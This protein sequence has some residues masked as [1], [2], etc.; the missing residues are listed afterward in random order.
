MAVRDVWI[1]KIGQHRGRP[2]LFLDGL[3]AVRAGFSPGQRF[4]VEVDGRRVVI[5]RNQDGSRVVSSRKKGPSQTP[6]V[7]INSAELLAAFEGM[8]AIRVVVAPDR[9]YLLP[10]ASQ[11]RKV[12]RVQRLAG[13]LATGQAL[14]AGSV[15]HGGGVLAHA[16]HTGLRDAGIDCTLEFANELR[17]DL[18]EQAIVHNDI[19]SEDTAALALPMQELAQDEWLL[20][21]LP[22]LELLEMGLPCSGASIAGHTKKGLQKME[23]HEQVGHL[24]YSALV[25]ISKTNPAVVLLENVPRYADTAS[26]AILRAQF[27]DMG[28]KTAEFLLDGQ[29]FGALEK[30]IRW[31]MVATTHGVEIDLQDLAPPVRLVRRLAEVLEPDIG[32][33]DPRWSEV[34]YLKDKEARNAAVGDRFKMQFVDASSTSVPTLRRHYN[35]GGSSDPRLRHPDPQR[36]ELSRLLTPVEHAGVKGVPPSLIAGLARTTAHELLGQGIAYEPF[37]AVGARIGQ[38][39]AQAAERLRQ[40]HTQLGDVEDESGEQVLYRRQSITG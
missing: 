1:K 7:D 3:Q 5:S 6:V 30:R 19:W 31:C 29:D 25:I 21:N 33:D 10:L 39:L 35:K 16:V 40:G 20:A 14:A 24:V 15:A 37:R 12:E 9:V 27:R 22:R 28:Y 26:A 13:K 23:D 4:D 18:L 2:R 32:P 36:P 38:C 17:D 8:D 11:A 34:Q